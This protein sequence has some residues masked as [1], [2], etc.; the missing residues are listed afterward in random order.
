MIIVTGSERGQK[1]VLTRYLLL[2]LRIRSED[3]GIVRE[4]W[5]CQGRCLLKQRCFCAMSDYVGKAD[6]SKRCWN[7]KIKLGVTTHFSSLSYIVMYFK[8][9]P[10]FSFCIPIAVAKICFSRI[11]INYTKIPL[12][13]EAPSWFQGWPLNF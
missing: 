8:A 1:H 4:T 3:L 13:L 10:L 11:V 7:L 2:L 9:T 5:F 12:N 6:L